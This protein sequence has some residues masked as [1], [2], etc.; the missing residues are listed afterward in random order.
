MVGY[1]SV[2]LRIKLTRIA[3]PATVTPDDVS[4][5][6]DLE[7]H[8]H[9]ISEQAQRKLGKDWKPTWQLRDLLVQGLKDWLVV[10]I[11]LVALWAEIYALSKKAVLSKNM[12]NLHNFL[13][14]GLSLAI[15]IAIVTGLKRMMQNMR[16][17][18]LSLKKRTPYEVSLI[19]CIDSL[20]ECCKIIWHYPKGMAHV[21]LLWLVINI[22]MQIAIATQGMHIPHGPCNIC[23]DLD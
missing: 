11:L 15:G 10:V 1:P 2:V 16:W 12:K 14:V 22:G 21:C 19:L 9:M 8:W 6:E 13:N 4:E 23:D 17:W 5:L 3:T 7:T 20:R 18:F